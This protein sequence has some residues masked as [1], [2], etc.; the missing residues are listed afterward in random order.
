MIS[1]MPVAFSSWKLINLVPVIFFVHSILSFLGKRV[2]EIVTG[3]LVFIYVFM[4]ACHGILKEYGVNAVDLSVYLFSCIVI[5]C[6]FLEFRYN[7]RNTVSEIWRWGWSSFKSSRNKN[8]ENTFL[9]FPK[10]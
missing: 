5:L 1:D 2:W 10:E 7:Q 6:K 9:F 8:K 3:E 4:W